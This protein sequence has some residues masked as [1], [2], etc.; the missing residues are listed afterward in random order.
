MRQT[1]DLI[2][3]EKHTMSSGIYGILR[4]R[5]IGLA[6]LICLLLAICG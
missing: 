3:K 6:V 2:P 1:S 5:L 4:R